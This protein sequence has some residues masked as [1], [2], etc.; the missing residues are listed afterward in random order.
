VLLLLGTVVCVASVPLVDDPDTAVDESD[1]QITLASPSL[2]GT[3]LFQPVAASTDLPKVASCGR[4]LKS[5]LLANE[6]MLP[7]T[8]S[9]FPSQMLLCTFLI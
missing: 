2:V 3:K 1:V 7:R 5:D 9:C 8:Q 6:F 4:E